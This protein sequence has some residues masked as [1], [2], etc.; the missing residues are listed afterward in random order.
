MACLHFLYFCIICEF[1]VCF[2]YIFVVV[3]MKNIS[4]WIFCVFFF[5]F[6]VCTFLCN[7]HLC[8]SAVMN[9][10]KR[11][12]LVGFPQDYCCPRFFTHR[13]FN[14]D[15]PCVRSHRWV[16]HPLAQIQFK[17][18]ISNSPR[19]IPI[20]HCPDIILCSVK[21]SQKA[22]VPHYKI[23]PPNYFHSALSHNIRVS[24]QI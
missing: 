9:A 6:S 22:A 19:F 3:H 23:C 16:D 4:V 8:L 1:A 17:L 20:F 14:Q 18:A 11:R 7:V 15:Y 2:L 13:G 24:L 5:H 21:S 12:L 10:A